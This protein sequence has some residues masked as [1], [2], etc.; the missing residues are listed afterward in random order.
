MTNL[1]CGTFLEC[2]R[3]EPHF[4]LDWREV[5]NGQADCIDG[6]LDEALCLYLEINE[7]GEEEYRCNN[8]LC[9]LQ[10]FWRDDNYTADC[11][12]RS[13]EVMFPTES[14]YANPSF[15]CEESLCGPDSPLFPCGDG[16][17]VPYFDQCHNARNF[18]LCQSILVKSNVSDE[19]RRV[20]ACRTKV[21]DN[22][23]G[24]PCVFWLQNKPTSVLLGNCEPIFQ[25]PSISILRGHV[26]LLY[27]N[28]YS[29]CEGGFSWNQITS[30]TMCNSVIFVFQ[31]FATETW[32]ANRFFHVKH[33]GENGEIWSLMS[34]WWRI[35]A[36]RHWH[37]SLE[38][39]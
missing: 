39:L 31:R 25:F 14:C 11:L 33:F 30:V 18:L 20:V 3:G 19:C 24:M 10:D 13:D 28:N 8:G 1:S 21:V 22:I 23:D 9:I 6:E 38:L 12:A 27:R 36:R 4:C 16:Q 7:C 37:I 29:G 2:N 26:R 32:L 34:K 5:C 35:H 15:L 17:C